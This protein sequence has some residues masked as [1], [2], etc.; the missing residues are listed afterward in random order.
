MKLIPKITLTLILGLAPAISQATEARVIAY[1]ASCEHV[2]LVTKNGL[3]LLK[4][5]GNSSYS[6]KHDDLVEGFY[7]ESF[8]ISSLHQVSSNEVMW[9]F[10]EDPGLTN[11]EAVNKYVERCGPI[12]KNPLVQLMRYLKLLPSIAAA[13]L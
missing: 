10:N 4:Q 7:L 1:K 3:L 11:Q 8:G 9:V 2:L 13:V 5:K 6:P 12:D